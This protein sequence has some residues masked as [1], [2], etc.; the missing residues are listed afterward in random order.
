M[1]KIVKED[2]WHVKWKWSEIEAWAGWVVAVIHENAGT[3]RYENSIGTGKQHWII[4]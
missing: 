1:F 2:C 4:L 3:E